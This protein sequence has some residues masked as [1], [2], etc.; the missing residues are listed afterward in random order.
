MEGLYLGEKDKFIERVVHDSSQFSLLAKGNGSE[1]IFQT[2]K[3]GKAFYLY[4]SDDPNTLEFFYIIEGECKYETNGNNNIHLYPGD[5]FYIQTLKETAYFLAESDMKLLWFTTQPAFHFLSKSIA[6]LT[7]VVKQVEEKDQY[8]YSHSVRVLEYSLRI[9]KELQLPKDTVENLYFASLFHDI[10]KIHVLEEILN[11][12]S[13]LTPEEFDILKKHPAD[14]C[15]MLKS[16]YYS[17]VGEIILQHH[18]RLDGSGYPNGLKGDQILLEA[19]IIGITDT[20][21]AMTSDRIY[22]KG[23]G[24]SLA[25]SEIKKLSGRHYDTSLVG[26][27]EKVLIMDGKLKVED[28]K[29]VP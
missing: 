6:E 9:A 16:T 19:Q 12:P 24:P 22:R 20:Y 14:G 5:Y 28:L 27:F 8:T 29:Q 23:V 2:I 10:G 13:K 3:Q 4:P 11:K 26:A 21:D 1:V 25:I 18:E 15:E 17:H 7:K